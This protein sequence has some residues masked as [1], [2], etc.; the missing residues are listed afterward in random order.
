MSRLWIA[1]FG[2]LL[3]T[4]DLLAQHSSIYGISGHYG[5]IIPHSSEL[6]AISQ[7]SPI[8]IQLDWSRI[9]TSDKAWE[10]CNCY[11]QVGLSFNYFN[12][13]N[14]QQLGSSYNLTYFAEPYLSYRNRVFFSLR[15]G[16]GIT[17]LTQVHDPIDN[18]QNTFY[19]APVSFL[20]VLGPNANYRLSD[21][22]TLTAGLH[23][24]HISNGGMKQPN[25]GM[26]FPTWTTGIKYH[27][28]PIKLEA[29]EK[30]NDQKGKLGG[31][32]RAFGTLPEVDTDTLSGTDN[33]RA[34]LLGISGGALYHFTHTNALNIGIEIVRDGSNAQSTTTNDVPID[35]Y[36]IGLMLG[37]NFVFGRLT[38]NQQLGWY[39][40]RDELAGN[41]DFYQR[42]EIL[43]RLGERWQVG[44][45]LLA[46]GHVADNLDLR[47]GYLIY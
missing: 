24:N 38:F 31:Y 32:I 21:H 29:R 42:Y 35:P 43:Y 13:Q 20:L 11:G 3:F 30:K 4:P 39:V 18:P 33:S 40:L 46:H 8:G 9:K 47:L 19:S 10:S 44:T 36:I 2:L 25:K 17:Y 6:K 16:A 28:Q 45:S 41:R 7:S 1:F 12:Y 22:V 34:L 14:R 37:H 15:A 27:P 26:N 23:Y 5:W